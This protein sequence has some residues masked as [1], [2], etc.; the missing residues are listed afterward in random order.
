MRAAA[1]LGRLAVYWAGRG[2]DWRL[3]ADGGFGMKAVR[4]GFGVL[5][6]YLAMF[7]VVFIGIAVVWSILGAEA[8]F[9]PEGT[10]ASTLWS[11]MVLASGLIAAITGGLVA[12]AVAKHE[13][14]LPA[15]LLAALVLVLGL[16]IAIGQLG[17]APTPLPEGKVAADLTFFEAGEVAR[18]PAWYNFTV[19]WI[20]AIGVVLG[21]RVFR[22]I[23][24]S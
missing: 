5:V 14:N 2:S 10:E 9:V 13:T 22:R 24:K 23:T 15:L 6:G 4:I 18:S 3:A 21:E 11:V 1:G 12:T 16:A 20:G 19:P 8:A 7:A 17:S